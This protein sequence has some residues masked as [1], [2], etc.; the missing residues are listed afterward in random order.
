MTA[1]HSGVKCGLNK[2][3]LVFSGLEE[4]SIKRKMY[5]GA[6]VH[7]MCIVNEFVRSSSSLS[8]SSFYP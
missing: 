2:V 7:E 1:F 5:I 3:D 4:C 6:Q 8:Y